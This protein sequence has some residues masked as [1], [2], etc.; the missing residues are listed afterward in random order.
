MCQLRRWLGRYRTSCKYGVGAWGDAGEI[1][2]K[3]PLDTG[4]S[5][6]RTECRGSAESV[7]SPGQTDHSAIADACAPSSFTRRKPVIQRR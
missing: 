3:M 1:P 2:R 7:T 4:Q 5:R 6:S